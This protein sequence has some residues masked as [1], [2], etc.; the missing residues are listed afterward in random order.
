MALISELNL[1]R[2]PIT[3]ITRSKELSSPA[4]MLGVVV[5]NPPR[6]MVVCV[7]VYFLCVVL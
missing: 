1:H 5:S 7:Q 2:Q 6:D 3:V 4:R